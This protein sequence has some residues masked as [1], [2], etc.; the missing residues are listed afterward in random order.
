MSIPIQIKCNLICACRQCGKGQ[1]SKALF[2][3]K[4]L[5]RALVQLVA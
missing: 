4:G 5:G 3:L 1:W 2:H